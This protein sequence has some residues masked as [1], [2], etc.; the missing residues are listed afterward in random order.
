MQ[1]T[2]VTSNNTLFLQIHIIPLMYLSILHVWLSFC[3]FNGVSLLDTLPVLDFYKNKQRAL[4]F[5]IF[6]LKHQA[7]VKQICHSSF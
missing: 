6:Q 4:S 2:K 5:W 7:W 1:S 3:D